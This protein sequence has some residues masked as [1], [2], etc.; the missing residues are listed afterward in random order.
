MN[1]FVCKTDVFFSYLCSACIFLKM[2]T[3]SQSLLHLLEY[4]M[5][6]HT[7]RLYTH[8]HTYI[9]THHLPNKSYHTKLISPK[10]TTFVVAV[11]DLLKLKCYS[12][13]RCAVVW[14]I[15]EEWDGLLSQNCC[16]IT[17]MQLGKIT[18]S[19][20]AV[21]CLFVPLIIVTLGCVWN[22]SKNTKRKVT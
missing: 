12:E 18:A 13:H 16:C 2:V 20:W 5:Q 14:R 7:H 17:T 21:S 1:I 15:A 4:V 22:A 19:L 10:C 11:V 8:I 6:I 9:H 3:T